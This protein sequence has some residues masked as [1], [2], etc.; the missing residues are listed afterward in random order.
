MA[1]SHFILSFIG[2]NVLYFPMFFLYEMPRRIY[3]YQSIPLWNEMNF[4]ATI[5]AYIFAG[6][7]ILLVLNLVYTLRSGKISPPNPWGATGLEWTPH[8]MG[9]STDHGARCPRL[10][11][12][13]TLPVTR[14]RHHEEHYS[15]RPDTA[16]AGS[17][18]HA[19]SDFVCSRAIGSRAS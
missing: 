12:D 4:I 16:R 9:A 17:H 2:F 15:Q 14:A 18:G 7:Q 19:S 5:G 1:M 10:R 8:I 11:G 6:A 3:T 13:D